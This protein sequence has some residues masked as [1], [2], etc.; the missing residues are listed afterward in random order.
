MGGIDRC[1]D[2]DGEMK[3]NVLLRQVGSL[4]EKIA[5]SQLLDQ[6]QNAI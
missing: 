6:L 1:D 2:H 4:T 3:Q 5:I